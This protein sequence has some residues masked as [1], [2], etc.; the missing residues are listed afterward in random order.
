MKLKEAFKKL[1]YD[2]KIPR[3][4]WSAENETGVCITIW[5]DEI[6]PNSNKHPSVSLWELHKTKQPFEEQNG[7]KKRTRHLKRAMDSFDGHIDVV[8]VTVKKTSTGE[9]PP[10]GEIGRTIQ[11]ADPWISEERGGFWKITKFC[12]ETGYF[13]AEVIES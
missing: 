11:M 7:H 13:S 9:T 6:K 12:H 4:D 1:G 2:L 3:Q 10:P 5:Q 8:K